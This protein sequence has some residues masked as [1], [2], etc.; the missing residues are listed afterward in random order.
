MIILFL[1]NDIGGNLNE[2]MQIIPIDNG[3]DNHNFGAIDNDFKHMDFDSFGTMIN[4]MNCC[5]GFG[6]GTLLQQQKQEQEH[7]GSGQ[8]KINTDTN[9]KKQC[10]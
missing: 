2:K 3:S 8:Q 5:F 1:M 6:F 9:R 7:Q 4:Q 10:E